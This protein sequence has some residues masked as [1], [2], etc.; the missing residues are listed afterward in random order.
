MPRDF[1]CVST[2]KDRDAWRI[3]SPAN[4]CAAEATARSRPCRAGMQPRSLLANAIVLQQG[5][6]RKKHVQN[7]ARVPVIGWPMRQAM[8][9]DADA[10][11]RRAMP[12]RQV[13]KKKAPTVV[14]AIKA[15]ASLRAML[16]LLRLLFACYSLR[17][18]CLGMGGWL[19][20]RLWAIFA[21]SMNSAR[22]PCASGWAACCARRMMASHP[23]LPLYWPPRSCCP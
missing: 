13:F 6:V 11:Y 18:G 10:A 12:N 8:K 23:M 2:E 5:P 1:S 14:G 4:A 19:A 21:S 17:T 22:K 20:L 15:G 7:H 9:T 3:N 16:R